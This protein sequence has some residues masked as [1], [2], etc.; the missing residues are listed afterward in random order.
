MTKG[1]A[2]STVLASVTKKVLLAA[3]IISLLDGF[4]KT[5][6]SQA[7]SNTDPTAFGATYQHLPH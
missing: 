6:L 5:Y 4:L 7:K 3:T 1:I 2:K